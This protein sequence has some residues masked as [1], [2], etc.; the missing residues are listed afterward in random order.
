M[1]VALLAA[2]KATLNVSTP[3]AGIVSG[4]V[5]TGENEMELPPGSRAGDVWALGTI[6][7]ELVTGKMQNALQQ[8]ENGLFKKRML[9]S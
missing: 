7:Y 6:L 4:C 2:L 5:G 9:T 8:K 3:P 1:N